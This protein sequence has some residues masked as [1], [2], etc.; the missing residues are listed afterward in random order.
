[1]Y[2]FHFHYANIFQNADWSSCRMEDLKGFHVLP[3]CNSVPLPCRYGYQNCWLIEDICK[4]IW[5]NNHGEDIK[6]SD[7]H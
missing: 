5:K 2:E 6:H 3:F 7:M 1:M 4:A